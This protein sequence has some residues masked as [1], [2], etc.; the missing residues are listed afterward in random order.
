MELEQFY[1]FEVDAP[2]SRER[3]AI[4]ENH[5]DSNAAAFGQNVTHSWHARDGEDFLR[6]LV[7]PIVIEIVFAG[8]KIG[9]YG[10]TP[11]WARLLFT[12][13]HKE[14]LRARIEEVLIAAGFATT[15]KLAAQRQ[16]KRSLFTRARNKS[17]AN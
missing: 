4:I 3:R 5:I 9:L 2:L 15:A 7:E 8:D 1:V 6:I 13:A 16:P 11:A 12:T 14:Q 17:A 10:A